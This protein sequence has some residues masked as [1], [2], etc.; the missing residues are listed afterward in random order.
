MAV[1][2]VVRGG[3]LVDGRRVAGGVGGIRPSSPG[4]YVPVELADDDDRR[5]EEDDDEDPEED[6]IDYP[7]DGGDD[8]DDE[9]DIEEDED[10]DMDIDEEDE[11]DEMDDEEA[12]VE[13]LALS[14]PS[15]CLLLPA[16]VPS[17]EETER[18]RLDES[19]GH[20]TP[21]CLT[22]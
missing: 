5:P 20:T 7:A 11:D 16:T 9:M 17:A 18:L 8:G 1:W 12:E 15:S 10:V 21:T 6:P 4:T 14:L 2:E 3:G 22:L 13:H 19:R